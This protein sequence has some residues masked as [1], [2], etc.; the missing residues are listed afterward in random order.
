MEEFSAQATSWLTT[1]LPRYAANWAL[2]RA[3]FRPDEEATRRLRPTARN[4]LLHMDAF[5]ARPTFGRRILRLFV[6]IHATDARVWATAENFDQLL[7]RFG[8]A[9]GLPQYD[10]A[11]ARR[12]GR[13]LLRLFQPNEARRSP[14]DDFML[15]FHHFLKLNDSYQ[16]R[17]L[18]KIW[19]F[20][21]ATAWLLFT[22]YVSHAEL[23]GRFALE[24]SYF[25]A[26]QTLSLP[27]L[28]PQSI[29]ERRCGLAARGISVA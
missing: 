13:G 21:P 29:L 28:A 25:I 19:H 17:A 22:D 23:R 3:T 15:R 1:I 11:W 18:K 10:P 7:E 6:N 12:V 24:H 5:A 16:E 27:D 26:P 20:A 4:D 14:Y 2:D 9:V 8:A